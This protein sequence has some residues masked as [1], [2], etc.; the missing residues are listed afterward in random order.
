[1]A[2]LTTSSVLDPKLTVT[3]PWLK[4]F[5]AGYVLVGIGILVEVARRLGMGFIVA[6]AELKAKAASVKAAHRAEP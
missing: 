6:R 5:T 3:D 2:T 1:V 4:L